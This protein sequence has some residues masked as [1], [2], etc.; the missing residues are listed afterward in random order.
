MATSTT[1]AASRL[2]AA[3][4]LRAVSLE[5]RR[6]KRKTGRKD[7]TLL[8]GTEGFYDRVPLKGTE[9]FY[10]RGPLEGGL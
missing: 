6:G 8:K 4:Q 9:G 10:D 1:Q 5:A 2:A 3:S 7:P